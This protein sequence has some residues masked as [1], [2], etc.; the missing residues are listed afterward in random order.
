MREYC[1]VA[2]KVLQQASYIWNWGCV[3]VG[4][5]KWV[6]V[7]INAMCE[8]VGKVAD[9]VK[10][11]IC[12]V[13]PDLHG[14]VTVT[15]QQSHWGLHCVS[16]PKIHMIQMISV[17]QCR[18]F[19]DIF[20]QFCKWAKT[21]TKQNQSKT[22]YIVEK[23]KNIPLCVSGRKHSFTVT[24]TSWFTPFCPGHSILPR[25]R[26]QFRSTSTTKD[27]PEAWLVSLNKIQTN[28]LPR[29]HG[30]TTH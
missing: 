21:V 29:S 16:A 9:L 30:F 15:A 18:L 22:P 3:V 27:S 4:R 28:N 8:H 5:R 1:W 7:W 23:R 13:F 14:A 19:Y 17:L 10:K 25:Q 6:S 24:V 12:A 26:P 20:T 2:F 11:A